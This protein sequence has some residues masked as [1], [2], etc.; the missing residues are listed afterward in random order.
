MARVTWRGITTDAESAKCWEAASTDPELND[1]TIKPIPGFGS[2]RDNSASGN[3]DNGGGHVDID[4]ANHTQAQ[5]LRI[6]KI[7]RRYGNYADIRYPNGT[8]RKHLHVLRMD[9]SDLSSAAKTQTGDYLAG[10]NGLPIGG[11]TNKDDGPRDYTK[12]RWLQIKGRRTLPPSIITRSQWGFKGWLNGQPP[13]TVDPKTRDEFFVHYNGGATGGRGGVGVPRDIDS[14]H[15]AN[16]WAGI[17]YGFVVTQDGA[18]YE[19]RG[20]GY[21]GAHCPDHNKRGHSAQVFIG[22]DEKPSDAALAS[23]RWLYDEACRVSGRTL[24]KKGHRDGVSTDCPGTALYNWVRAG[25]PAPTT[26]PTG[27]L[28]MSD[29]TDILNAINALPGRVLDAPV[30][31]PTLSGQTW[32]LRDAMWSTNV[33]ALQ[34]AGKSIDVDALAA[35]I[36]AKL[37]ADGLSAET[38]KAALREVFADAGQA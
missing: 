33:Y 1:V 35:A 38:V 28:S 9:C 6:E 12:A 11:R 17:G 32:G 34:A 19:G 16:G 22:G 27:G 4:L 5:A 2:Y 30:K 20:F 26:I 36:V 37:P 14:W 7:F 21:V 29:V 15:K 8:W 31:H 23:V 18:I 3:T 24:A 25:M 10:Y 13:A